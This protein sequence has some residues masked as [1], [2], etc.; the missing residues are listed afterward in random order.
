MLL[1]QELFI[2]IN[3]LYV[4]EDR[5]GAKGHINATFVGSIPTRAE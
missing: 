5:R 1:S 4:D 2:L 3:Y